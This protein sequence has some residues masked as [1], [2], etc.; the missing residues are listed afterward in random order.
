MSAPLFIVTAI[1]LARTL[2]LLWPETEYRHLCSHIYS[3]SYAFVM[4]LWILLTLTIN[5]VMIGGALARLVAK[6]R[7]FAERDQLTGLWNRRAVAKKLQEMHA[8]MAKTA[9]KLQ[10]DFTGFRPL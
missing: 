1:F 2:I 4:V 10:S 6:I 7:Q 9:A 5:I 3:G 8:A